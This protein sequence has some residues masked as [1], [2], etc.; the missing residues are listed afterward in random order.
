MFAFDLYD[1]DKSGHIDLDEAQ[2]LIKDVYGAKFEQNVHARKT[3]NK[4]GALDT[5]QIDLESFKEFSRKHQALL[6]PAFEMQ[7]RFQK[8]VVGNTFWAVY[9]KQRVQVFKDRYIPI[10]EILAQF[11]GR[12]NVG[13]KYKLGHLQS[14][15]DVLDLQYTGDRGDFEELTPAQRLQDEAARRGITVGQLEQEIRGQK[16]H[17]IRNQR[18]GKDI[19]PVSRAT[20]NNAKEGHLAPPSGA[21]ESKARERRLLAR[22]S[23]TAVHPVESTVAMGG[24]LSG[25]NVSGGQVGGLRRAGTMNDLAPSSRRLLSTPSMTADGFE[26][27]AKP[28]STGGR[29]ASVAAGGG[30]GGGGAPSLKGVARGVMVARAAGRRGSVT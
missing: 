15:E 30:G 19:I 21:L 27:A 17:V 6:Y 26:A 18:T 9:S 3:Y 10:E 20:K 12:Y 11:E 7:N 23:T 8:C 4:L 2:T 1:L 5:D 25:R 22:S 13:E 14:T 16:K 24:G 29:R 28:V